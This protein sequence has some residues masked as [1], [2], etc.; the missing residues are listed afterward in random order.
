MTFRELLEADREK[1]KVQ[2]ESANTR[3]QAITVLEREMDRL[4]M[5]YGEQEKEADILITPDV[6]KA[7]PFNA[8]ECGFCIEEGEKATRAMIDDIKKL[9]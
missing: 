2:L 9:L 1:I 7:N 6:L 5:Q 4:L 8:K 3:E